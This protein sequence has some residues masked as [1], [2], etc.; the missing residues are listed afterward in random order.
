LGLIISETA[1]LFAVDQ[2][3]FHQGLVVTSIIP[4]LLLIV[5]FLS[6]TLV[7][8]FTEERKKKEVKSTF[9]K[10]VSPA[11]VNEILSSPEKLELGG[12][13]QSVTIFFSDVRGFTTISEKLD[14][15]ALSQLLNRYLTPM[16]E[17]IFKN[18][19]TLDKY[20]GDAIMAFFGAPIKYSNHPEMAC[21]TALES[22][23]KLKELQAEFQKEGLPHIDI[24]IGLNTAAVSVGNMGSDIVRNY[25]VMGDG[26]NLASR[27]EGINKEYGTRIIMSEYTYQE[28]KNLFTCR[29]VDKVRV[30]GK[31][32]PVTIYELISRSNNPC[33]LSN[34]ELF[35][36]GLGYYH[37]KDFKMALQKFQLFLELNPND[38][39]TKLYM[40]RTN[41]Y[42]SSPPPADWDGVHEMKTK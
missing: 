17:I 40:Q 29:E 22:V 1:A 15:Q 38:Y 16:T 41:D 35:S 12:V 13:K 3:L 23:E 36:Q 34:L 37:Q 8:Y 27:L 25:T 7:K 4:L 9:S 42:I 33:P 14:P 18:K 39:L 10:Y 11:I 6:L 2:W 20:M 21:L 28:V 26:V 5:L 19:G 24:G 30:K 32:E 31:R